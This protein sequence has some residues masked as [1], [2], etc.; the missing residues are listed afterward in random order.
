MP[1]VLVL[2]YHAVSPTFPAA[3]SVTPERLER[4]LAGLVRRGFQGRRSTTPSLRRPAAARVAV[5]FDDAY[6][7]VLELAAPI[8]D[9]SAFR[10]PSS[11]RRHGSAAASRWRWPG[12]DEWL[13][14]RTGRSS[15]R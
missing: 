7:S 5:T 1:D 14:T 15:C 3:L 13:G 6:R 8:L 9:G 11:R 12:I 2:C 4:Q 10:P